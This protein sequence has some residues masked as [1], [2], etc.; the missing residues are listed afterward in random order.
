MRQ[1]P[2]PGAFGLLIVAAQLGH[3]VSIF[4]FGRKARR[5]PTTFS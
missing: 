3:V 5:D 2:L 4:T 1:T